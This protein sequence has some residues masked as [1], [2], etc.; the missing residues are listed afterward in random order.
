M[1]RRP[2]AL[3]WILFGLALGLLLPVV[4]FAS[5]LVLRIAAQDRARAEDRLLHR[6]RT[7]AD[8]I[9]AE[10]GASVRA[11]EALAASEELDAHGDLARFYTEAKR[12]HATQPL[13]LS[14]VLVSADGIPLEDT[15]RPLGQPRTRPLDES[16]VRRALATRAPAFGELTRHPDGDL[17]FAIRVPVVRDDAVKFVLSA[18]VRPDAIGH[19]LTHGGS[20]PEDWTRVVTDSAN[21]VVARTRSP[22]EY[23]GRQATDTFKRN[24]ARGLE[25]L[26]ASTTLEGKL[27]YVGYHRT[28]LAGWITTVVV[29]RD[30]IDG[31]VWRSA[32]LVTASGLVLLVLG[33]GGAFLLGRKLSREISS[34]RDAA[35][36][37]A[38]GREPPHV[39]SSIAE[40]ARLDA[41]LARS[42]ELIRAHERQ[43][44]AHLR[45]AESARA[46]AEEASHAKDEF[47][48]ML[49]HELRNPLSPIL[50]A[51]E[52]EKLR[53]GRLGRELAIV[54]RQVRH[55]TRLVEDLVDISRITRG[56]IVLRRSTL[57]IASVVDRAV[58]MTKP[59]FAERSH[60]LTVD[61]PVHGLAVDGDADRL[62]QILG[63]LLTNAAKYTPDKGHVAVRASA[64][65]DHVEIA[66]SD[67]GNGIDPDLLPRIFDPFVQGRRSPAR[68]EGGLGI[69]LTL[70]R[71][72][73]E[74]HGGTVTAE[75]PGVGR[76]STFRVVLPL[77]EAAAI[78]VDGPKESAKTVAR[79]AS[80]LVVDDNEDAAD[81]LGELLASAG[82]DVRCAHDAF[83]AL[84]LLEEQ[85]PEVAILDI[86]LPGMDGFELAARIRQLYGERA[87]VLVAL[88]GYGQPADRA[89]SV[90]AGFRFHLVKPPDHAELLRLV[91]RLV[92]S[93]AREVVAE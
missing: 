36:A 13:W 49:G 47:M 27:S 89:R 59:L 91:A 8:A 74:A 7:L 40:I 29:L 84:E 55:L 14:V 93:D 58:E 75:S 1:R 48:A 43:R 50:A 53:S 73:V 42:S 33:A 69:G 60:T 61:V 5:V 81:L 76:G 10:M 20:A 21:T 28:E 16:S 51:L 72:L 82:H 11:L 65:E 26:F 66:L 34:A 88:T 77:A 15:S 3:R 35:E 23:V 62:T 64:K 18:L 79:P 90:E 17:A 92:E 70:V 9:D 78:G 67:D 32:V 41:A 87:P 83:E 45:E 24:T 4:V 52:V 86:G 19:V 39:A 38:H 54:E 85:A 44:E 22:A 25:G 46:F 57:E 68:Q 80:V 63:N 37:L 56:K 6:A 12:V 30:E 71:R 2:V 31:P